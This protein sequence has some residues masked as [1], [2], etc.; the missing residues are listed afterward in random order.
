MKT[1]KFDRVVVDFDE[2]LREA[3]F[4]DLERDAM[5]TELPC[6]VHASELHVHG[7]YLHRS[8]TPG[9]SKQELETLV[10]ATLAL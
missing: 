4:V 8:H 10:D 6:D 9:N 2:I 5:E 1:Y 7:D 3:D